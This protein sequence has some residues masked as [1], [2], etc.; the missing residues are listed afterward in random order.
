LFINNLNII[1]KPQNYIRIHRY[2]ESD[3]ARDLDP[4]SYGVAS[5]PPLGKNSLKSSSNSGNAEQISGSKVHWRQDLKYA[6][7]RNKI[8]YSDVHTL[9]ADITGILR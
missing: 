6:D 8:I 1:L 4:T 3:L 2:I 5:I 7:V 9:D